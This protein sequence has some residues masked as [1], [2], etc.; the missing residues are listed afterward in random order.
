M[1]YI[2]GGIGNHVYC[3][4]IGQLAVSADE[5]YLKILWDEYKSDSGIAEESADALMYLD[6]VAVLPELRTLRQKTTISSNLKKT[7]DEVIDALENKQKAN[8]YQLPRRK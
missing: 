3:P 4:R 7:L 5:K 2:L 8:S 6:A 1:F